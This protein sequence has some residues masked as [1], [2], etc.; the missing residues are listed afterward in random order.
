MVVP[1]QYVYLWM[2]LVWFQAVDRDVMCP[3]MTIEMIFYCHVKTRGSTLI[4]GLGA[5][6]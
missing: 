6:G 1:G 2:K 4:A 3:H 5:I